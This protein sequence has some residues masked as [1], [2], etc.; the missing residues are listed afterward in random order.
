QISFP[1]RKVELAC[2]RNARP[3]ND[4]DGACRR[5]LGIYQVRPRSANGQIR[6]AVSVEISSRQTCAE[7]VWKLI[8]LRSST[9]YNQINRAGRYCRCAIKNMNLADPRAAIAWA[10]ATRRADH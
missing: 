4:I 9:I 5:S 3:K 7:C 8:A 2:Q 10:V 6:N 1:A